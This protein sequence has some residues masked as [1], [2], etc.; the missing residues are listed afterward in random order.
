MIN[1]PCNACG[2]W[3]HSSEH[4]IGLVVQCRECGER[5]EVPAKSAPNVPRATQPSGVW[6]QAA[7]PVDTPDDPLDQGPV[8][9]GWRRVQTSAARL[10][11]KNTMVYIVTGIGSLALV[12]AAAVAWWL[13]HR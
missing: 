8:E 4:L 2:H 6:R 1:H 11:P 13:S 10:L 5:V 12:A 3:M 9:A 7:G